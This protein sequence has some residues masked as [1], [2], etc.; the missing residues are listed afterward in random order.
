M[1]HRTVKSVSFPPTG[2]VR[3]TYVPDGSTS[4]EHTVKGKFCPP[5]LTTAAAALARPLVRAYL[6]REI[7]EDRVLIRAVEISEIYSPPPSH[8]PLHPGHTFYRARVKFA[9]APPEDLPAAEWATCTLPYVDLRTFPDLAA[10]RETLCACALRFVDL[11][12][13]HTASL[14]DA[15]P[16][17][18]AESDITTTLTHRGRTVTLSAKEAEAHLRGAEPPQTDGIQ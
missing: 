6:L 18:A 11:S 5:K 4:T 2:G 16:T 3:V 8:L 15:P 17:P 7:A 13:A 10:P 14:F 12:T 1:D 9:W